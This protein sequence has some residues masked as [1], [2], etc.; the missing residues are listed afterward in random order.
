VLLFGEHPRSRYPQAGVIASVTFPDGRDETKEFDLPLVEIPDA[1]DQ[2]LSDKVPYVEDRSQME[3]ESGVNLPKRAIREGIVNALIHRDYDI[4]NGKVRLDVKPGAIT[5]SSPGRPIPPITLDQVESFSAPTLSRNPKLHH[6]FR[7]LGLAE[8]AGR[9]MQTMKELRREHGG[10]IPAITFN[11]PYLVLTLHESAE[12]AAT[13]L[14]QEDAHDLL[15]AEEIR[16]WEILQRADG[17]T[18][19]DYAAAMGVTERTARRHLNRFVELG[20]AGREGRST[21][22]RYVPRPIKR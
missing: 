22:T 12:A 2:W 10:W 6:I 19:R 17:I 20:L 3:R 13:D 8:E 14:A 7:Q 11:D 15:S 1:I 21:A 18:S 16:G 9:G 4:E 5:I